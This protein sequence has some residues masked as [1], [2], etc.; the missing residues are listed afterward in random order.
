MR[1]QSIPS[2]SA[3]PPRGTLNQM[4]SNLNKQMSAVFPRQQAVGIV[5]HIMDGILAR[6]HDIECAG[7]AIN[8]TRH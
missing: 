1:P 6:R 4:R 2:Q 8:P 3:R 7:A 5:D